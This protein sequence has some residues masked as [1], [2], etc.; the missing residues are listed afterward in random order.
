MTSESKCYKC[1]KPAIMVVNITMNAAS[2]VPFVMK[3]VCEEHKR[4]FNVAVPVGFMSSWGDE[5]S[6]R[7]KE[8][9]DRLNNATPGPLYVRFTDDDYFMNMTV[10]STQKQPEGHDNISFSNEPDTVA[11]I[12]H[13]IDPAVSVNLEDFGDAN[14]EFI[15][16][17][18]A[19]MR[20]LIDRLKASES[21]N[22]ELKR[23]I[24]RCVLATTEMTGDESVDVPA[25][26]AALKVNLRGADGFI[27]DKFSDELCRV[28]R[29]ENEIDRLTHKLS[30]ARKANS[31][32]S[33]KENFGSD[34]QAD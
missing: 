9:A 28:A 18:P 7:L 26:D 25:I 3:P 13:Q 33:R 10:I 19:D 34:R 6:G 14:A 27:D 12:F 1:G 32:L 20:Y 29:L 16:N 11:I 22:E 2:S 4:G 31:D 15:A 30:D 21:E 24:C 23:V 8:V 17:C 5:P